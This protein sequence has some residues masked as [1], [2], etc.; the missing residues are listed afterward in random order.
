MTSDETRALVK[1]VYAAYNQTLYKNTQEDVF[2]VWEDL[3]GHYDMTVV[4]DTFKE[5]AT[6]SVYM[7]SPGQL[8][9]QVLDKLSGDRI[10][11]AMEAWTTIQTMTQHANAGTPSKIQLHE[12]IQR[13]ITKLGDQAY[14]L[15]TTYDRTFFANEYAVTVG[16]YER[17]MMQRLG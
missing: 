4:Y 8:R 3:L 11:S 16:E 5:L 7:P 10:P 1:K 9:R 13:T 12:C 2:T 17:E 15:S 6:Q 14:S